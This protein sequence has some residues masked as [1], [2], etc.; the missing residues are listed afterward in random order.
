MM[1]SPR[2]D[3]AGAWHHVMN[4]DGRHAP[5]FDEA[6]GCWA[7]LDLMAKAVDP[8]GLEVHA[9]AL[10]PNHISC[11]CEG[12]IVCARKCVNR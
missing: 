5:I 12:E 4:R 11:I 3:Y 8:F 6:D 1:R 9:F 7:F 10:M 2:P